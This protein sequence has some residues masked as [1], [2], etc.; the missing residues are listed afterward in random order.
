MLVVT[1]QR[2]PGALPENDPNELWFLNMQLLPPECKRPSAQSSELSGLSFAEPLTDRAWFPV[3]HRGGI[4]GGINAPCTTLQ[5]RELGQD[6]ACTSERFTR[7]FVLLGSVCPSH[8]HLDAVSMATSQVC[9]QGV[10]ART[11]LSPMVDFQGTDPWNCHLCFGAGGPR[12]IWSLFTAPLVPTQQD[13]RSQ[14]A[15]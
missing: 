7:I 6:P 2:F 10:T 13:Q 8:L 3:L 4:Q 5:G 1:N 12:C 11:R 15:Q 9:L 14:P